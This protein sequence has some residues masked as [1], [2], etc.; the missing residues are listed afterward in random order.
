MACE[1]CEVV[2]MVPFNHS[3]LLWRRLNEGELG[4]DGADN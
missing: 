2:P 4:S 1:G 3:L